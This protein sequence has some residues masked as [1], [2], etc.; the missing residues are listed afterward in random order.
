MRHGRGQG[1]DFRA[2]EG[3]LVTRSSSFMM[4]QR[5]GGMSEE[6]GEQAVSFM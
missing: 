3:P 4:M 6:T 1:A 5:K 2:P